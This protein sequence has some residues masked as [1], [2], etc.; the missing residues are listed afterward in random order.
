MEIFLG[1]FRAADDDRQ[2]GIG[3]I[4]VLNGFVPDGSRHGIILRHD[5]IVFI[6][7]DV[8]KMGRRQKLLHIF[9]SEGLILRRG[10]GRIGVGS[11]GKG[12]CRG[13]LRQMAAAQVRGTQEAVVT[14]GY[15]VGR[16]QAA[17]FL[18]GRE[19]VCDFNGFGSGGS[20][21]KGSGREGTE[22]HG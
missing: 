7:L 8:L 18:S 4:A 2:Q 6:C 14:P 11:A 16:K 9:G 20:R 21:R 5:G 10:Q 1:I 3:F 22:R 17:P 12:S 15:F 13:D 19:A